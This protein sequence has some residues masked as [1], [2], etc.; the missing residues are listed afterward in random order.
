MGHFAVNHLY[1]RQEIAAVL[2]GDTQSYLP[3]HDG[4][5]VCACVVPKLNPDA[6]AVILSGK[7]PKVVK[8]GKVFASQ[9]E[10]VPLF[11]KRATNAWQYLGNYRVV[12]CSLDAEQISRWAEVSNRVGCLSMVLYLERE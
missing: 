10:F 1:T 8:W 11:L 12:E 9:Q 4:R 3:N 5:V 7:G 2:G 6:P